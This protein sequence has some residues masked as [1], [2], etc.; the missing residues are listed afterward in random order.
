MPTGEGPSLGAA[1]IAAIASAAG[2]HVGAYRSYTAT[3]WHAQLSKLTSSPRG[4]QAAADAGLS[5]TA[6]TL[7]AWLSEAQTPSPANR[8]AIAD[9]Y[10]R[11]AGAWP[12][13][14]TGQD[15]KISG[16]VKIGTDV[17]TRGVTGSAPLLIDG[18]RGSWARIE[19]EWSSGAPDPD[20]VED[21]FVEDLLEADLGEQTEPWEFPGNSY[22]VQIG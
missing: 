11:M 20:R 16:K 8:T 14:V 19:E 17:R 18:R 1:I 9:A 7:K 10:R 3:G 21:H 13:G 12:P 5:A 22:T 2:G 6:R 15:I 4:Y